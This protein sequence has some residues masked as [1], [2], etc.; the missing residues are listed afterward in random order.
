MFS[1]SI[2]RSTNSISQ[3]FTRNVS[4]NVSMSGEVTLSNRRIMRKIKMGKARPA[5][6]YQFD[7]LV[8]LSDGSVVRRRSQAPKDEIRMISDQR[9]SE[10]WNPHRSDLVSVDPNSAGKIQKFNE[11]YSLFEGKADI[12]SETDESPKQS[13]AKKDDFLALLGENATEVQKGGKMFSKKELKTR[14]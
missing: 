1:R 9:N 13:S 3:T 8:E 5:I 14:K 2:V 6:F 10:L 7:T 11:R 4:R 12:P